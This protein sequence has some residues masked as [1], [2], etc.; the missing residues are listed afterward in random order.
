M[1]PDGLAHIVSLAST[2]KEIIATIPPE[3][4]WVLRIDGHT[5]IRPI[6]T[7]QFASN[8]DLSL[9]RAQSVS[10]ALARAGIPEERLL[11]AGF[12]EYRP[13]DKG[14]NM[15]AYQRN[16]RIEIRLDQP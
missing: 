15:E 5:D 10:K 14:L 6:A 16:R 11:P 7:K 2:L 13:L 12:G 4:D 9:A 8:R 1:G 3:V